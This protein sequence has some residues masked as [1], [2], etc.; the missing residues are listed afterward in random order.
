MINNKLIGL[1]GFARSGKDTF[2]LRSSNYLKSKGERATRFAFADVLKKECDSLLTLNTG[3]SAF[4][5]IPE[6]KEL[7]RPLLVTYGT[8]IRRRLDP[9]CW[10]N[11]IKLDVFKKISQG[12]YVFIT[13]V[14]YANEAKWIQSQGGLIFNIEREGVGPANKEEMDESKS[15]KML[16][17]CRV[18]WPSF[19]DDKISLCDKY[20]KNVLDRDFDQIFEKEFSF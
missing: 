4:T 10:I 14:R 7:I 11:E 17:N 15:I 18:R 3:I 19:G 1:T 6:E 9:D 16:T 12:Y 2:F 5:C 20:V 8:H 13:D